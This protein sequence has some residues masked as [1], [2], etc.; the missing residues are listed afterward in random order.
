[1]KLFPISIFIML[2]FAINAQDL[3]VATFQNHMAAVAENED[4]QKNFN[5]RNEEGYRIFY[6]NLGCY[7]QYHQDTPI[8]SLN[9]DVFLY[10]EGAIFFH[11]IT[12]TL[13]LLRVTDDDDNMVFYEFVYTNE[14]ARHYIET[15]FVK[16]YEKWELVDVAISKVKR[17]Y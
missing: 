6:I 5:I 16:R 1:M 2:S 11:D 15:K 3:P 14:K 13:D 12:Y 17:A 9:G 10:N 7:G 8:E 4:I